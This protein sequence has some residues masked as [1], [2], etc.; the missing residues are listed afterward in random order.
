MT[1]QIDTLETEV[2][3]EAGPG[4][5][6]ARE[7]TAWEALERMRALRRRIRLERDRLAA[8]DQDDR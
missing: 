4:V 7:E 5:R 8:T 3:A 2:V 1:V 6:D